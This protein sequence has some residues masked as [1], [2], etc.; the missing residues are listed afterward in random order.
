[1]VKSF[2][3]IAFGSWNYFKEHIGVVTMDRWGMFEY[4]PPDTAKRL[5]SLGGDAIAFLEKLPF[6]LCTEVR[7]KYGKKGNTVFMLIKYS[8]I[9]HTKLQQN[10]VSAKF[11]TLIDFGEVQFSHI[12][13]AASAF[14]A[15]QF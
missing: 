11:E 10:D 4:T 3:Y 12:K 14:G 2:N 7:F 9:S 15:D 5:E 13:K 1:M 6:F 8:R